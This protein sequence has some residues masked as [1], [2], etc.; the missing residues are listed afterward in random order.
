VITA[1]SDLERV[2]LFAE[3]TELPGLDIITQTLRIYGP[4]YIRPVGVEFGQ[5]ISITFLV[6]RDFKVRKLFEDWL[7]QVVG[8]DSFNI[9]YQTEY[10]ANEITMTQLDTQDVEKYSIKLK[11][12]FPISI[13]N[14]PLS[15]ASDEIHRM[16]VTFV[17]RKWESA[18]ASV[19]ENK[20]NTFPRSSFNYI[21]TTPLADAINKQTNPNITDKLV[22]YSYD[23]IPVMSKIVK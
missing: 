14:M 9:S 10:V 23:V 20:P 6:D 2:S 5:T 4:A 13:K 15:Y 3:A 22:N 1:N 7:K 17:Y 8:H 21:S 18:F 11:D 19:A 16:T 12:A